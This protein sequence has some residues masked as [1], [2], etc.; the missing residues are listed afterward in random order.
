M[1]RSTRTHTDPF[2]VV[3]ARNA[4]FCFF[5]KTVQLKTDTDDFICGWRQVKN[6]YPPLQRRGSTI[7]RCISL[8]ID[9]WRKE[10]LQVE[11][12]AS[13]C[14]KHA[15]TEPRGRNCLN[16]QSAC[17]TL[18]TGSRFGSKKR[19]HC[20]AAT[21]LEAVVPLKCVLHICNV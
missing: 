4:S 21:K 15:K 2:V 5:W 19:T 14:N 9:C 12:T 18:A 13:R 20:E 1:A 17:S 7:M 10:E 8:M 16:V 3:D 6:L 11:R